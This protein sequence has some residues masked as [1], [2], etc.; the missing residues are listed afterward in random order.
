[1]LSMGETSKL[2]GSG[3]LIL[4]VLRALNIIS[5]LAV[6]IASWMMIV[7]S[8]L[9]GQFFFFDGAAHFFRFMVSTMLIVSELGLCKRYFEDNWPV[10]SA[11]HSLIWL[12][13]AMIILGVSDLSNLNKDVYS[14][15]N[16]GSS[17]WR[18]VLAAG[19]L[20]VAFGF[21]N[22]IVSVI[23]RDRENGITAR[24]I[25]SDGNLARPAMKDNMYDAYSASQRSGSLRQRE[26]P[27][28]KAKRLTMRFSKAFKEKIN[29]RKSKISAPIPQDRDADLEGGND[30]LAEDRSSPVMPTVQRPPTALHPAFT[31]GS[32][33]SE[34]HMSRF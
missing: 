11:T 13:I 18:L 29:V 31:G 20:A 6:I 15:D 1:M 30:S 2:R 23:F 3:H 9:T 33:Y 28:S 12:G 14:F 24:Q 27:A 8:G 21:F 22:L 25:R 17:F 4:N 32:R 10:L 34:A 16:L 7:K 5:L 26:E 19:I